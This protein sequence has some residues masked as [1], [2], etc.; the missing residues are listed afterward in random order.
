MRLQEGAIGA[1]SGAAVGDALGGATEGF[2]PE[3]IQLRYNGFVDG[4]V[5]PFNKDWKNARP[6]SPFHK[7]DGHIT[8]D[9]LM[10]ESLISIYEKVQNHLDAY[11]F[12]ACYWLGMNSHPVQGWLVNAF[13][14]S[15][16]YRSFP[17]PDNSTNNLPVGYLVMGEGFQN[18]H[19]HDAR[20]AK[21][22]VKW[23]EVDTGF[24]V[25]KVLEK[26]GLLTFNQIGRAH[27]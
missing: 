7:G 10:T 11:L 12:A 1:I 26:L 15:K 13:G 18:N 9:T 2:S 27:V 17:T 16:G 20:Q 21:F 6:V 8:D 3:Q 19:H 25:C 22:S 24:A 14:H 23:W 5:G 4:V